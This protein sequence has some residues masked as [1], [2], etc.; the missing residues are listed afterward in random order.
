[1]LLIVPSSPQNSS[2]LEATCCRARPSAFS[3]LEN[4]WDTVKGMASLSFAMGYVWPTNLDPKKRLSCRSAWK[5]KDQ[6]LNLTSRGSKDSSCI[7]RSKFR[8]ALFSIAGQVS[9][10]V[11]YV[12]PPTPIAKIAGLS[13]RR[14]FR[15]ANPDILVNK[16]ALKMI[17]GEWST[18]LEIHPVNLLKWLL[19]TRD[20]EG[21]EA[22]MTAS[23]Y[24]IQLQK[25]LPSSVRRMELCI[26]CHIK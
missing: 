10:K 13:Q 21:P 22:C 2:R 12:P 3:H 11:S 4:I 7:T 14:L 17:N 18:T 25:L 26:I 20:R 1:M 5:T 15:V 8:I 23:T 24:L 6:I 19:P 16:C 9:C